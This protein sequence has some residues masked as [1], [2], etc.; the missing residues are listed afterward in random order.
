MLGRNAL[1]HN[2]MEFYG[3]ALF[4]LLIGCINE[5]F[6]LFLRVSLPTKG[7]SIRLSGEDT[8]S[9]VF[10]SISYNRTEMLGVL[11]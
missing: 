3:N 2:L 9:Q 1:N 8:S 11:L 5:F 6:T 4:N 7:L 10:N